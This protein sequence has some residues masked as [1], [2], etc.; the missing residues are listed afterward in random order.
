MKYEF[1][2]VDFDGTLCTDAFPEIGEPNRLVIAYVKKLAAAGSKI[3]LHTCRENGTRRLLDEAEEFCRTQGIPLYAVN[4]NPGNLH[5]KNNGLGPAECRKVYA[6]LYIDDKAVNPAAIDYETVFERK[7]PDKY[8]LPPEAVFA[9][10]RWQEVMKLAE[11]CGF[12]LQAAGG[13]AILATNRVQ[14]EEYGVE[15]YASIQRTNGR[16]PR[17]IGLPGCFDTLTGEPYCSE[18]CEMKKRRV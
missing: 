5:A 9:D 4:I 7:R 1:V 14:L 16:C 8:P 3:I 17:E 13:T 6:N 10:K 12:I 15:K 11:E 18:S 2:A